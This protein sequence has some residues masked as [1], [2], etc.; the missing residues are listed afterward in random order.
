M[1]VGDRIICV[2]VYSYH[3]I[4]IGSEYIIKEV[5]DFKSYYDINGATYFS[6]INDAGLCDTYE[7]GCFKNIKE[8]RKLKLR[9]LNES[10]M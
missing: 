7:S 4:T 1:K 3:Y 6:L 2:E 5:N 8:E 9:R 10:G